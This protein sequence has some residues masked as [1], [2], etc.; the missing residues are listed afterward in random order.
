MLFY[1]LYFYDLLQGTESNIIHNINSIKILF[2]FFDFLPVIVLCCFRQ[3]ILSFNIPYLFLLINIA[4]VFNSMIWGQLDSMYANLVFL[5]IITAILYPIAGILLYVLA[6]NTKLQAIEFL[7]VFGAVLLFSI[8]RFK[9]LL[10]AGVLAGALEILIF[11]PYILAGQ[12]ARVIYVFTHSVDYYKQ[13]SISAFNFWYMVVPGNPYFVDSNSTLFLVSYKTTGLIM[14]ASAMALIM[15]PLTKRMWLMRKQA[16]P[17]DDS[18]YALLFLSAGMACLSF[19]YFNAQMHERYSHPMI[20][21]FFFYSVASKNYRLYILASIPYFLSLDKAFSFPD[22]YLP[23][24]HYKIIYAS[25]IIAIWY[26]AT[27][28]YGGY[29]FYNL[30]RKQALL[31]QAN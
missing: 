31:Q 17:L 28:I 29:L 26:T 15:I 16:L 2:V 19:F 1:G 24:V 3:R 13:L 10:Y 11:L 8:K 14:Y 6:L 30:N 21:F 22:G 7:P 23:I 4:Y 20:I 12:S 27:V 5:A 9:T 18:T 25:R